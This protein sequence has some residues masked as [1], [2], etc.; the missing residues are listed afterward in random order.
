[1]RSLRYAAL[2]GGAIAAQT[3]TAALAPEL[4]RAF[5]WF[6]LVTVF[7]ALGGTPLAGAVG[8]M[9]AGFAADALSGSP[10]GLNGFADTIAGYGSAYLAQR[11]VVRRPTRVLMLFAAVSIAQQA[12]LFALA[13]LLL[14]EPRLP[15]WGWVVGRAASTGMLGV[16]LVGLRNTMRGRMSRWRQRKTSKLR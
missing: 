14:P 11:L 6:L 8:G 5:D 9:V 16:I 15:H 1:M 12:V 2:V 10:Y 4:V 3:A 7:W 13:L